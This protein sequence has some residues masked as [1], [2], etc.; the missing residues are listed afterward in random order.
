VKLWGSVTVSEEL[1]SNQNK[2]VNQNCL[3]YEIDS[4]WPIVTMPLYIHI[5]TSGLDLFKAF[6]LHFRDVD[7]ALESQ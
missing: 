4:H 2:C 3:R 6:F 1:V 5:V 7:E